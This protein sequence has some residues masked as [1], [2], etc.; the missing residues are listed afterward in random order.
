MAV[1]FGLYMIALFT[2][3]LIFLNLVILKN[4]EDILPK[5]RYTVLTIKLRGADEL[6]I[7]DILHGLDIK[8]LDSKVRFNKKEQ[9]IEQEFSLRYR[10][11]SQLKDFLKTLKDIP[12]LLEYSIS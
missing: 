8:V 10:D 11:Y 7:S 1:G 12:D 4:I 3:F 6:R 5:N 2:F 9:L